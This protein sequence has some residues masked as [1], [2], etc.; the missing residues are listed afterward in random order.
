MNAVTEKVVSNIQSAVYNIERREGGFKVTRDGMLNADISLG[1]FG[2]VINLSSVA[3]DPTDL[4]FENIPYS[5]GFMQYHRMVEILADEM[6]RV[7][8]AAAIEKRRFTLTSERFRNHNKGFVPKKVKL[9][10]KSKFQQGLGKSLH[11]E[12][13]MLIAT[14]D[15]KIL[16]IQKKYLVVRG[17]SARFPEIFKD[18]QLYKDNSILSDL[19]TYVPVHYAIDN[20]EYVDG[21]I[22]FRSKEDHWYD[23]RNRV[24]V[25]ENW[26]LL[27]CDTPHTYKAMNKT[28]DLCPRGV[29]GGFLFNL[30]KV[31]LKEPITDRVKISA[32]GFIAGYQHYRRHLDCILRS[33]PEQ[34]KKAFKI[35]KNQGETRKNDK[36]FSL[37]GHKSLHQFLQYACDYDGEHN[38]EI[39]GLLHKSIEWH[40]NAEARRE[41]EHRAYLAATAAEREAYARDMV[42]TNKTKLPPVDLPEQPEIRFLSTVQEVIDEGT[43]MSHCIGRYAREA[44]QGKCYLFHTELGGDKASTMVDLNGNITQSYGPHNC[45]NKASDWAERTLVTWCKKLI[46]HLQTQQLLGG[47]PQPPRQEVRELIAAGQIDEDIGF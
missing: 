24:G 1:K 4:V 42:P 27:F 23:R 26:R 6:M 29:G 21:K 38:G 9:W 2:L 43:L 37:R 36:K 11:T 13:K 8:E 12:W 31:H 17:P 15:P 5:I 44:V 32:V 45:K 25:V 40:N 20:A 16:A 41:L 19:A 35:Y 14:V 10:T 33:S 18:E 46:T 30:K 39:V 47:D 3:K 28:L 22:R 7:W 34:I